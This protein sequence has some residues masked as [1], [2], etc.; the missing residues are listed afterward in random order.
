MMP[1][2]IKIVVP[3]GTGIARAMERLPEL[4]KSA[5]SGDRNAQ[6]ILRHARNYGTGWQKFRPLPKVK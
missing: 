5:Q 3:K 4:I 2:H 1:N 6:K